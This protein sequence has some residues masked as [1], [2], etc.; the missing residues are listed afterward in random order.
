VQNNYPKIGIMTY[1][2][3]LIN[4]SENQASQKISINLSGYGIY[5]D[6]KQKLV[7]ALVPDHFGVEMIKTESMKQES[8]SFRLGKFNELDRYDV[9][10]FSIGSIQ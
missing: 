8:L 7:E 5:S 6:I 9:R 1:Y 10:N 2:Y 4:I 3:M